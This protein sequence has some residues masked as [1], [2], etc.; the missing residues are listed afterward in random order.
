MVQNEK[1]MIKHLACIM[2]GNRRWAKKRGLM[3]WYGHKEGAESVRTVLQFCLEKRI[4]YLSLY[5]FSIENFNRPEEEKNYIFSFLVQE[6]EHELPLFIEQG[7]RIIFV[8]DRSLF[9]ASVLPTCNRIEQETKLGSKLIVQV[10]FCYGS[11]QEMIS[12]IKRIAVDVADKKVAVDDVSDDLV[13]RYLWTHNA[14]DPDLIIRTGG[15]R[16][17]SNFMLYQAAYSELFFLDCM[18]PDITRVDLQN[19]IDYFDQCKRNFGT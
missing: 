1:L 13:H 11:R 12:S 4:S 8:G 3:P 15:V 10:M 9:P 14:P 2:D 6:A 19:A 16:R 7:I 17:L 18:W 5:T